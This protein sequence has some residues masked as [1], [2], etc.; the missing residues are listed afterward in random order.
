M[1]IK[2]AQLKTKVR[3]RKTQRQRAFHFYCALRQL[4]ERRC[5][6]LH[7]IATASGLPF[8]TLYWIERGANCNLS[9][10]FKIAAFFEMPVEQLWRLR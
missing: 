4:R 9:T 1:M 10:A 5:L 7:E 2:F 6:S 3:R 8:A